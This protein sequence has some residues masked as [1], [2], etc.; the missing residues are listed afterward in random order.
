MKGKYLH[1]IIPAL[2]ISVA[3]A[4]WMAPDAMAQ[5]AKKMAAN[6]GMSVNNTGLTVSPSADLKIKGALAV[7]ATGVVSNEGSITCGGLANE[8]GVFRSD[9]RKR[10]QR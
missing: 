6:I 2:L 5:S 4:S 1:K 10:R 3:Y 7:S 8:G 9:V